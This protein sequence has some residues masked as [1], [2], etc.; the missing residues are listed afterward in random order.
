MLGGSA[1]RS[2]GV[3]S[4]C[5]GHWDPTPASAWYGDETEQVGDGAREGLLFAC[6]ALAEYVDVQLRAA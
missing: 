5:H 3:R 1:G 6:R 4:H 2:L